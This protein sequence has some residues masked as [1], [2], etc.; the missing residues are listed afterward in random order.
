MARQASIVWRRTD[1]LSA[2]KLAI[3]GTSGFLGVQA[4]ARWA[5]RRRLMVL[6][7]HGVVANEYSGGDELRRHAYRNTVSA[8]EFERHMSILRRKYTPVSPRQVADWAERGSRLPERAVLV[9]FDDGYRNNLT[10][11]LPILQRHGIEALI[12]VATDYIGTDRLLWPT[13]VEVR[14][15][16]AAGGSG[17]PAP[18]GEGDLTI[19]GNAVDR[20][21][22]LDG[23]RAACKRMPSDQLASYLD[24][25]RSATE[26]READMDPELA[27]FLS[28]DD[29]RELAAGSVTIASHTMSHPILTRIDAEQLRN[30]L[31]GSK[32][33][34]ESELGLDC[35]YFVYPNGGREDYSP[36]VVEAVAEAGYG[37]AFRLM[38]GLN[39]EQSVPR[40]AID[41]VDVPGHAARSAFDVRACGLFSRLRA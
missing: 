37:V 10:H 34:I 41:R 22:Q 24:R 14:V 9:T 5:H 23:I 7:Y 26:V 18:D 15:G 38:N 11:A 3:F 36:D 16:Q 17:I 12:S 28:W 4:W 1:W 25:L 8:S 31:R 13:E 20:R 30:E 32:Q 6:C 40:F 35:P 2:L 21:V 29:V 19:P 39:P 33:R 27:A